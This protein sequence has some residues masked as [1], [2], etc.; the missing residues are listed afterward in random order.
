MY[1]GA[2]FSRKTHKGEYFN[3]ESSVSPNWS[4]AI[5]MDLYNEQLTSSIKL[6]ETILHDT[7]ICNNIN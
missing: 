7:N 2:Y 4:R 1:S 5:Q 3:A 6:S